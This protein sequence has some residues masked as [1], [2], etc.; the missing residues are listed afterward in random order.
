MGLI[1]HWETTLNVEGP[2]DADLEVQV[3]GTVFH[4]GDGGLEVV[5]FEWTLEG[6]E[7]PEPAASTLERVWSLEARFLEDVW[8]N[9]YRAGDIKVDSVYELR[10]PV[11]GHQ[12]PAQVKV[13]AVCKLRNEIRWQVVC[14]RVSLGGPEDS[15]ILLMPTCDFY[16]PGYFSIASDEDGPRYRLVKD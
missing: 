16:L 13:L 7:I 2:G 15:K 5:T 8:E 3:K 4:D 1:G 14:Q 9:C 10:R 11:T 6:A 12:L